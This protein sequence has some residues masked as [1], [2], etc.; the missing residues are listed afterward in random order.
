MGTHS[1]GYWFWALGYN[2]AM[3]FRTF[4]D[5]DGNRWEIRPISRDEWEFAP[6]GDNV[7]PAR[8]VRPPGYERD[9]YELSKE[10]LQSLFDQSAARTARQ[11]RNP[12]GE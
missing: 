5:R 2:T 10:E 11:V 8:A 7:F 12:F 1:I 9:P 6:A 3:G 4:S